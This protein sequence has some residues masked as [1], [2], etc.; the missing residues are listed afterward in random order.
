[1]EQAAAP[2]FAQ[3]RSRFVRQC[4]TLSV[5]T[6]SKEPYTQYAAAAI[7]AEVRSFLVRRYQTLPATVGSLLEL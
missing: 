6:R 7:F 2:I 4:Q 1:M 3:V 5:T